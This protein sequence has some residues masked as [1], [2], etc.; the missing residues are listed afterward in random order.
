MRCESIYQGS[1]HN[2]KIVCVRSHMYV[3]LCISGF[4]I[5]P[6]PIYF[7]RVPQSQVVVEGDDVSFNCS[8][9]LTDTP[10]SSPVFVWYHNDTEITNGTVSL[11]VNDTSV[12]YITNV[13]VTD[14]GD[15]YCVVRDWETRT[16]SLSGKLTSKNIKYMKCMTSYTCVV[17]VQ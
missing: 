13:T 8:A 7:N 2:Q 12:L 17:S 3:F 4:G 11:V 16:R 1:E 14:Q 6:T 9:P 10:Y 15:Y 5:Q